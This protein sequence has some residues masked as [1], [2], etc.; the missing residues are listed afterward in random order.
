ML[1]SI[2]TSK[3]SGASRPAGAQ[4]TLSASLHAPRPRSRTFSATDSIPSLN[5]LAV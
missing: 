1:G 3:R 2:G 5:C 4:P